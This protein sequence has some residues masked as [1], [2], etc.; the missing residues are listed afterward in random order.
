MLPYFTVNE[1]SDHL[2]RLFGNTFLKMQLHFASR[3]KSF[4][5]NFYAIHQFFSYKQPPYKQ[6]AL[7]AS[8]R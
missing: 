2:S 1:F 3:A 8:K 5:N 4:Y 7:E 6:R